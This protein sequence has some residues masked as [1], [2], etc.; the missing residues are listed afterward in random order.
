MD[1][2]ALTVEAAWVIIA[3]AQSISQCAASRIQTSKHL[4]VW[5]SLSHKERLTVTQSVTCPFLQS[6]LLYSST[7]SIFLC[8]LLQS[9]SID[10]HPSALPAPLPFSTSAPPSSDSSL[11]SSSTRTNLSLISPSTGATL[12]AKARRTAGL[13][14]VSFLN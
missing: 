4:M 6:L 9:S 10:S 2:H 12:S 14:E 8:F 13:V 11:L 3:S 5:R 1:R 7:A